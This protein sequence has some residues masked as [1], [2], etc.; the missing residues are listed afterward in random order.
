MNGFDIGV[1]AV[2]LL[3]G[4]FA[5]ARGFVKEALAIVAWVG[6]AVVAV[7]ALPYTL[8][9]AERYLPKG[10]VA[11]GAAG[12]A[13]FLV[14]LV[15]LSF[16]TSLVAQRVQKSKL[17]AIDH[18]LGLIF[19]LLRGVLIV[20]VAW[21]GLTW[22]LPEGGREPLPA[23]ITE[24]KTKPYLQTGAE[25]LNALLPAAYRQKVEGVVGDSRRAAEAAMGASA[26]PRAPNTPS[27]GSPVYPPDTRRD[28]DRLMEQQ[29]D[30]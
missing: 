10:V 20:C 26:T 28:M 23:W 15:V 30:Q 17:S 16:A 5:F 22:A 13:V 14:V 9:F 24:A 2:I 19:G 27:S 12:L 25:R 11:Y 18:T 8:P 7:L 3:S 21:L 6:A 29:K 1:I 4:L